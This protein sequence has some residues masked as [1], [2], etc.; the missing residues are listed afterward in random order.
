MWFSLFK[1]CVCHV[2]CLL[3]EKFSWK[4]THTEAGKNPEIAESSVRTTAGFCVQTCKE[5]LVWVGHGICTYNMMHLYLCD[6]LWL[7]FFVERQR[8]KDTH[9]SVCVC[10]LEPCR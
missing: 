5:T 2:G 4:T 1:N 3:C 7:N 10:D 9:K 6:S 8:E